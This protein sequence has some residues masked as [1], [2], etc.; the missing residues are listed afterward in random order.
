MSQKSAFTLPPNTQ[1]G[2]TAFA[3]AGFTQVISIQ[4]DGHEV[5]TMQGSGTEKYLGTQIFNSGNGNVRI[6]VT[7]NGQVSDA[8]FA[9]V[10]MANKL[11]FG[12][13][14]TEDSTDYDYNDA[15]GI[16]NWPLG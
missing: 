15:I 6:V 9:Q 8:V 1:F 5:G 10:T 14:G 3:N 11:N 13:L 16:L 4:V 7:A 12:L 2:F